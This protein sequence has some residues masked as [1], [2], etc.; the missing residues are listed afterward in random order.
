MTREATV[1]R[2]TKETSIEVVLRLEGGG[3]VD[4]TTGIGMLNHMIE[5]L[6]R[7]GGFDLKVHADGDL[8]VDAHHTVEDIGLALG[9]ALNEALGD[10]A[11]IA[12]MADRTV[13]L[14]EAL[15]HA[16]LDLSGRPYTDIGLRFS[17]GMAGELPTPLVAHFFESFAQEGR[18][19]LHLRQ[20]AGENDHHIMESAFKATARALR[21]AV[22]VIEAEGGAPSTKGTLSA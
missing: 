20:L 11:G 2:E 7:H 1:R 16:A 17:A 3:R 10:R 14:D 19:A 22:A 5:Q 9:K 6:G 15:V 4:V 21:D 13:P 12:R 8:H 18:F